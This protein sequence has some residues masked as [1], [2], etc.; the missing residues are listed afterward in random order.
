MTDLYGQ[1]GVKEL[2]EAKMAEYNAKALQSLARVSVDESR[3]HE[4][5]KILEKLASREA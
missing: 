3:K 4:L 5:K 1:I 2:C